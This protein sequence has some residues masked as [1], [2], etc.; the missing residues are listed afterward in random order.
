MHGGL[1]SVGV[2]SGK[3]IALQCGSARLSR[4]DLSDEFVL[5]AWRYNGW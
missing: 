5:S 2:D 3:S 1:R 4:M